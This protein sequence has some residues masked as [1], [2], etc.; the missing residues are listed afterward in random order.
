MIPF[1][2]QRGLGQDLAIHLLNEHDNEL[3]EIA[4]IRGAV[5][6]DLPGAFAEWEAQAHAMTK[7][8]KYLYSLSVNPD[9][10]MGGLTREQYQEYIE[11]VE[12]R[13]GLTGQPRAIV[14][15][16]KDDREH[17]HVVWSRTDT[18]HCRA[19]PI[20]F[21]K[22]KLMMET[23]EFARDHGIQLPE[24]YE[25]Y[26]EREQ[27]K[28]KQLSLYESQKRRET[29]LSR[30]DHMVAVTEAWQQS[31]SADAFIAA[32]S[33]KGYQLATGNRPYVLV[34]AYGHTHA[35]PRLI[36]DKRVR[37]KDIRAFLGEPEDRDLP[38]VE[39]AQAQ[40]KAH[41]AEIE[42]HKNHLH[43]AEQ[44]EKLERRQTERREKAETRLQGLKD[45]QATE[46]EATD[47][48]HRTERSDARSAYL[49]KAKEIRSDREA[50]RPRGL[51]GFLGRVTGVEL[52]RKKLHR[53]QDKLRMDAFQ[54]EKQERADR[55][56]Q[57]RLDQ[58]HLHRMRRVEEER[59]L[60]SLDQLE[61]RELKS[62]DTKA[63]QEERI[64]YRK[65]HGIEHQPAPR[66][67]LELRPPGRGAA[68]AKAKNR[69]TGS[70][71]KEKQVPKVRV[72]D[73]EPVPPRSEKLRDTFERTDR[74]AKTP[75]KR[76][77][78]HRV[79]SEALAR[80]PQ[81]QHPAVPAKASETSEHRLESERLRDSFERASALPPTD[82]SDGSKTIG[83]KPPS[84]GPS[85]S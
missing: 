32:L 82:G 59:R 40:A 75:S 15:H 33:D 85:R 28:N 43:R 4:E 38:D 14:F 35:L 48:R 22:H 45:A 27:G 9:N 31:D 70:S 74:A 2:S 53:H 73:Q 3:M 62:L 71:T 41:L 23:R 81:T 72:R 49:A 36:D 25:K 52:I 16:I 57:A 7:A 51:A 17:A 1:G 10:R 8:Q 54:A 42:Q 84:K 29:G 61:A 13:L 55:Q 80:P 77:P 44:H 19:I 68:P 26:A 24:G 39:T 37:T 11:R 60:R 66:P 6:Q 83:P 20:P 64:Q 50:K 63:L 79:K 21:D 46:R 47:T 30:A 56:E 76:Q 12:Q 67:A 58:D 18:N 69:F 78:E 5:A 65:D 34:D